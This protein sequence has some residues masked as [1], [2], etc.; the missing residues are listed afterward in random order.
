MPP[1]ST[2]A[3]TCIPTPLKANFSIFKRGVKGVYQRCKERHL[4]RYLAEFDFRFNNR[5]KLHVDD[6]QRTDNALR[7]IVGRRLTFKVPTA[8]KR[9]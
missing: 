2:F 3:V 5:V 4:H 9:G 7:G 8:G 6:V 1:E